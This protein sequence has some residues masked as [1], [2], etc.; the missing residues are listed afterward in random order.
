MLRKTNVN[1]VRR[2][3][4]PASLLTGAVLAGLLLSPG[5]AAAATLTNATQVRELTREEAAKRIPVKIR[6][7]I[8]DEAG[9][10]TGVV[11]QDDTAAVYVLGE[12]WMIAGLRRGDRVEVEG[13][14]DPG[15]FAPIVRL[16]RHRKI[17]TAPIPDPQHVTF[18][19]LLSGKF[20]AQWVEVSGIVRS[21]EPVSYGGLRGKMELATGGERLPIRTSDPI[22]PGSYVDAEVTLRGLCF[23]QHNVN[24][25]LVSPML[26]V[27]RGSTIHV[28][29]PSPAEPYEMPLTPVAGL[30]QFT[31]RGNYGHRVH[32]RGIVTHYRPGQFLWIREGNRGLKIQTAQNGPVN[33]GDDVSVLGFPARGEY[34]PILEDAVFRKNGSTNPPA[35]VEVTTASTAVENDANLIS[36]EATIRDIKHMF[37]GSNAVVEL[38]LD[39]GGESVRAHLELNRGESTPPSWQAESV[40]RA[41]GISS[42]SREE[43]GPVSGIWTPSSFRLLLRSPA[44]I[45]IVTPPPQWTL[46]RVVWLFLAVT[47][48]SLLVAAGATL[49]AR[50]RLKEQAARRALA[51]AEFAAILKERNRLAREMHDTLAQ[52]LGAISMQLELAKSVIKSNTPAAAQ[53]IE[54]AH[55][56]VRSSLG[57]ARNSIWNMRSQVLEQR[58]VPGALEDIL[59]QLT[60]DTGVAAH[61]KVTGQVRRLS[62]VMENDLLRIGQEAITNAVKHAQAK[63]IELAVEFT[64]K[65]VTLSVKD[66]GRGYDGDTT[67]I[68]RRG[69]GLVGMRE[70]AAQLRGELQVTSAPGKGTHVRFTMP[71]PAQARAAE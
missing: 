70:R 59:R 9:D 63:H 36:L 4:I 2:F 64:E 51:E 46:E 12:N 33:V 69:F 29:T 53:H 16:Q 1:I 10:G 50:R 52:G 48:A 20:D 11:V 56:Q 22:N 18:E 25:Q 24:R 8:M 44:D 21:S 34:T 61:C 62:P 23:N 58:D 60:D 32:V 54:T 35:P 31:P 49:V 67:R 27:P 41:T 68:K 66:D 14:S 15:G 38:D 3:L 26:H 17:G 65:N 55:K 19:Q 57:E 6:G 42:V 40:V 43:T 5:S 71:V 37:Q 45:A 47:I 28:T 13:T 39:W 7:V 30:L